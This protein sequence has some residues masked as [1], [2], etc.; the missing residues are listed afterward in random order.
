MLLRNGRA[1]VSDNDR[2]DRR[3]SMVSVRFVAPSI[4]IG[5]YLPSTDAEA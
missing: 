1:Q 3:E 5:L 4:I 2:A